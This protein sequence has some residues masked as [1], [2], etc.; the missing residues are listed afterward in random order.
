MPSELSKPNV[1]RTVLG[2][3]R[4]RRVFWA[5]ITLLIAAATIYTVLSVSGDMSPAKLLSAVEHASPLWLCASLLCMAGFI[6]LEGLSLRCILRHLGYHRGFFQG[7][8]Y[9]AADQFF[10]AI[11]PSASGGQPAA[12]L[13]MGSSSV[14][15]GAVTVTLVLNLILYTA[16][17]LTI[18]LVCLLV[19]PSVFLG[20]DGLSKVLVL[21]GLAVLVALTL[22]FHG[23]L[24]R[25]ELLLRLGKKLFR[26][27]HRIH[28]MRNPD[29]WDERLTRLTE[30]YGE[31]AMAMAGKPDV[32]L[33]V[34]LLDLGQRAAQITVTLT[35]HFAISRGA[36]ANGAALWVTQALAQI[37]SGCVPIPGGMGAADYLMLSGFQNLF[38]MEYAFELQILSRGVSFYICTLLSG[39]IVLISVAAAWVRKRKK[40][41]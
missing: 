25:G 26:L 16:A 30:E 11:T 38:P 10:S 1:R 19:M 32:W 29:R 36:Q 39:L 4:K 15:V 21:V 27:L 9:A 41:R 14:R 33:K 40:T 22:L 35:L 7:L 23:L 20:L 13:M 37:G 5:L 3:E 18:G 2:M 34:Y 12:A 31:C 17:T 6:V 24:R 28:L 8:R